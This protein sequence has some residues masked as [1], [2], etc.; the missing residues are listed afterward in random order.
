MREGV[1]RCLGN[2]VG[3]PRKPRDHHARG[4]DLHSLNPAGGIH[5]A[6]KW[7]PLR[8]QPSICCVRRLALAPP[9]R[10]HRAPAERPPCLLASAAILLPA[11]LSAAKIP[12]LGRMNRDKFSQ[13]VGCK[14]LNH[15]GTMV[16]SRAACALNVTRGVYNSAGGRTIQ[17]A[18]PA[19]YLGYNEKIREGM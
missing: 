10:F 16:V 18:F 4:A 8:S 6:P 11:D 17:I 7:H 14:R 5:C 3:T 13:M 1:K 2:A 9:A 12:H 19:R 15:D